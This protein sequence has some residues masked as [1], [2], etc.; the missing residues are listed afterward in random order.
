LNHDR[1]EGEGTAALSV[2]A[3]MSAQPEIGMGSNVE[4]VLGEIGQSARPMSD[5]PRDGRRILGKSATG[6]G[7]VICHW[8][9]SPPKLAGPAWVEAHEAGR[10]YLDRYFAGWLDPS[11]LKLWDYASLADLLIAYIDDAHASG[12]TKVLEILDRRAKAG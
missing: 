12:D 5:A 11:K 2:G 6:P 1:V 4:R 3:G 9:A 10:G 8:D 7:L